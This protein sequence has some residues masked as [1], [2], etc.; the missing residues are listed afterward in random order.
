MP[1]FKKSNGFKMQG[2]TL[3]GK[4]PLKGKFWDK[5]KS[6]V[7][8]NAITKTI[9]KT[10]VRGLKIARG[11]TGIGALAEFGGFLHK[12]KVGQKSV[13][14]MRSKGSSKRGFVGKI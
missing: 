4:S 13:N 9:G 14:R 6:T 2:T 11:L 1:N 5:V 3:Y 10:G 12:N 7:R 8:D